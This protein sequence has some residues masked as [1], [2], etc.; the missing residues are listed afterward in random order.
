MYGGGASDGTDRAVW[1]VDADADVEGWGRAWDCDGVDEPEPLLLLLFPPTALLMM[2]S[3]MPTVRWLTLT[4]CPLMAYARESVWCVRGC[5]R[6]RRARG[7]GGG[8]VPSL[9][10][11]PGGGAGAEW[12]M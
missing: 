11:W 1:T 10:V 5:W 6:S 7:G 12:L 4:A 9:E 8:G 2:S 3:T